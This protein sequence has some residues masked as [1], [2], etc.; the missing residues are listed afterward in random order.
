MVYMC[1]RCDKEFSHKRKYNN[2]L[3]TH[4]PD[5]S[6]TIINGNQMK[7]HQR[8]MH[9]ERATAVTKD[10]QRKQ[11]TSRKEDLNDQATTQVDNSTLPSTSTER[12]GRETLQP[13]P[14]SDQSDLGTRSSDNTSHLNTSS[15]NL[16]KP[17]KPL[18]R[19]GDCDIETSSK[20]QHERSNQH[21]ENVR[22]IV[23]EN[24]SLVTSAFKNRIATYE[25]WHNKN[26]TVTELFTGD[27]KVC[28]M[29][30]L[31]LNRIEHTALKF[32]IELQ[33]DYEKPAVNSEQQIAQTFN[34]ITK[35]VLLTM[36]DDIEEL[37]NQQID[38][39][40]KEMSE[41]ELTDSGWSLQSILKLDININKVSMTK[42][43]SDIEKPKTQGANIDEL[44]TGSSDN[45]TS[46]TLQSQDTGSNVQ[47][48]V[49]GSSYIETP[50]SLYSK[51]ACLNI[52][53]KDEFCFKWSMV[54]ALDEKPKSNANRCSSYNV[55]INEVKL[56][57][58]TGILLNFQGLEFP[59]AVEDVKHFEANNP[60]ISVNVFGY[61]NDEVVGP[62]YL[63]KEER[64]H[65]ANLLLLYNEEKFH[66]ICINDTSRLLSGQLRKH[67]GKAFICNQCIQHFSTS[68]HLENHKAECA[69]VV[70]KLPEGDEAFLKFK[71]HH[72]KLDVPF[73]IYA[74]FES[75]LIDLGPTEEGA[76][77]SK[78]KPIKKHDP[79][80]FGYYIKCSFD[81]RLNRFESYT[82][83][84][85][86]KKFVE[87]II[88]DCKD[89]YNKY[90]NQKKKMKKLTTLQ[91]HQFNESTNCHI[92]DRPLIK[93]KVKDHCHLTG[94]YRGAAHTDCNLKYTIPK[95]IPIY[96]HNF[97]SYDAHMFAK[98]LVEHEGEIKVIPLNR[99]LYVSL[100][101]YIQMSVADG[102]GSQAYSRL[103]LRFLD[104]FRFMAA[105]LESLAENLTDKEF[106]IVR[107]MFP[108]DEQFKLMR[109]KGIYPYDYISSHE[110]L[111]EKDLP[112]REAFYNSMSDEECT[113]AEYQHAQ[114]VWAKFNCE[115]LKDYM[116]L[117]LKA[118]V[119]ILAD[120][121]ENFRALCRS[122]HCLD[123]CHYFTAP[124]LSWDAMLRMTEIN[125][126]LLTDIDMFNFF[127]HGIRG[128]LVQCCKRHTVANNKYMSAYDESKPSVCLMYLDANNLYGYA[129]S[130]CLPYGGFKWEEG[131][132]FEKFSRQ[133][134]IESI[135]AK[136][137]QGFMYEVDLEY[138]SHLHDAHNDLPFCAENKLV[139]GSK[140]RK[141]IADLNP[142]QAYRLHYRSLQQ[143]LRHGL[144]LKNVR[145]ILSFCQKPWLEK[146]IMENNRHRALAKNAFEKDFFKLLNNAVYG[147]TMENVDKRKDVRIV[148]HWERTNKN[149][150]GARDFI[151]KPNFHSLTVFSEDM[152]AIQ[153]NRLS[154]LYDKPIYLGF[155]VLDLS[156]WKMYDFHY[157][158]MKK[159]F[160]DSLS[161]NYMDTDSFVYTF[162]E[163]NFYE[164]LTQNDLETQFDTS[165]YEPDN[166]FNFPPVNKKVLG[167]MKDENC[168]KIMTEFVGLRSKMYAIN[169]EN[170]KQI[171]KS[172][173]VKKAILKRYTIDTYRQVL[174]EKRKLYADMLTFRSHKH[175]V[176]TQSINKV[177]LCGDDDKRYIAPNGIDTYAW[178]HY[179]I[180]E[181]EAAKEEAPSLP[182]EVEENCN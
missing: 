11:M 112:A 25:Y 101:L 167:M 38:S 161:L 14:L 128:G 28:L 175:E 159:K 55:K 111:N 84:D 118:D 166:Q 36:D 17:A 44:C 32:N 37:Y 16:V 117:Y 174:M 65:H 73:A 158:F 133:E 90:L 26:H 178:G 98:N 129:M 121:F 132:D 122:I 114:Q 100:S 138:P 97:S 179:K 155:S 10:N 72:R 50:N 2:H 70:T 89:I 91:L 176:Y 144:Q 169:V 81:A 170:S 49:E 83:E 30:L 8:R 141:L 76:K 75:A 35:M 110:K 80:A 79:C 113:V 106:H 136:G 168:G 45:K 102:Q 58:Q 151:A 52:Q 116:E 67:H 15:S 154:V 173:G 74:D 123:A 150:L 6:V 77:A 109:K 88:R 180:A 153:M 24:L 41:F 85:A 157:D 108:N 140:C 9:P 160:G 120:V 149:R 51:K 82:G 99:E 145:R 147:K 171:K 34:H 86:S 62:Y 93:D 162:Q 165:E 23:N 177:T 148:N 61:E 4:C 64:E 172:K 181:I 31:H 92:C 7:Q 139:Q 146:Y 156:K 131:I 56:Q 105:S 104:S 164:S 40:N 134:F 39:L 21:K 94:L 142:K 46:S 115:S 59:L 130:Q 107:S 43:P 119:L 63:T 54:A 60:D 182:M 18:Y 29:K 20:Y 95:F 5:C 13:L 33:C 71:Q 22:K 47:N 137:D 1:P 57:L 103:E 27:A 163:Q 135:A 19:C 42:L 96:F 143:C 78:Q 48:N 127:K 12:N 3:N 124:G 87:Y 68:L 53:N 66:Y 125:L 152:A 69:K 126:E